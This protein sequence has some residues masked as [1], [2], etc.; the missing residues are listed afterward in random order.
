MAKALLSVLLLMSVADAALGQSPVQPLKTAVFD[1]GLVADLYLPADGRGRVPALIMLGGS[2]G[3][4]DERTAWGARTLAD[5]GYVVLQ[6]AYIVGPGLP[7]TAR[8][9]T[10]IH[11]L[12][13][14]YFKT[15]IDWLRAHPRV[16]AERIGIVGTS[17]GGMAA[18]LV[19]AH[20]PDLKVV[21][22]AVP[23]SVVWSTFGSPRI[24]MVSLAGQPLPYVPYGLDRASGVHSG[25]DD[26]LNAL[27][28][29][30]AIIPVEKINGPVMVICGKL[31]SLW[32]SCRMSAQIIAR[33][34]ASGFKH[35]SQLLEYADAGHSV[36]GPVVAP[37]TR[38]FAL[39]GSLGGSPGSN[40]AARADSWPKSMVF[41][42]AALQNGRRR[43]P[44]RPDP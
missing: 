28:H 9:P 21:V 23:S 25:F 24:S 6:L 18:L 43:S 22:A 5:H 2:G 30:D 32:P 12:P 17:I 4:L 8:L 29:P 16:D 37:E 31:D 41:I 34:E 11:L 15:A 20:Y 26:G 39:L 10:A 19:A 44:T 1:N 14:E 27:V 40:N 35:P 7:T 36:F 38:A 3:G 33:L 42:A 13:L